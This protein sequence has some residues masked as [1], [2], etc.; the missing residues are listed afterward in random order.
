MLFTK[1]YL[2]YN[3]IKMLKK[4]ARKKSTKKILSRKN[5]GITLSYWT[6]IEFKGKHCCIFHNDKF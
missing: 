1:I 2:N 5:A 6:K 3:V 4:K